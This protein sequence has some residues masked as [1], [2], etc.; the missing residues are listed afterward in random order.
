MDDVSLVFGTVQQSTY[1]FSLVFVIFR[2][3]TSFIKFIFWMYRNP[4]G[5]CN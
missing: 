3:L 1:S 2:K 4:L 5:P